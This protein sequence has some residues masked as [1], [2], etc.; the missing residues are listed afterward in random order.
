MTMIQI[1]RVYEP[2]AKEDGA[3]FLAERLWPRGMKKEALHMDAWCKDA[4]PSDD[5]RHWFSHDPAKWKEFQTTLSGRAR[6]QS[7]SLP[8]AVGRG[9]AGQHYAP[10]QRS[11]HET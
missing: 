7:C 4:A 6:R 11:R 5:L 2:A 1:K 10:I 8:T 9:Q 3:R